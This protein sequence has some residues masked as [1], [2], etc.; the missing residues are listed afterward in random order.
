MWP[1]I[2]SWTKYKLW[3][4]PR[5]VFA[6]QRVVNTRGKH[7]LFTEGKPCWTGLV[8]GWETIW[9]SLLGNQAG[10]VDISHGFHLYHKCCMRIDFQSISTWLRRFPPGT[11]ISSLL[12]IDSQSNPSGYGAVLWG[13]TWVVFRGR[14]PS[15]Q[16]SS[17]CPTS[18]SCALRNSVYDCEKGRLGSQILLLAAWSWT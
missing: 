6:K 12:K 15:R 2:H 1:C 10:V 14:A 4:K 13:H 7:R 17:F 5:V 8:P 11:Q 9:I 3:L 16:H 18:L